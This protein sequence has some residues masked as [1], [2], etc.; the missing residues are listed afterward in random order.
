MVELKI[1]IKAREIVKLT[2][3][4]CNQLPKTEQYVLI[5]QMCR[6][7]ISVASNI[8]EGRE[9]EGHDFKRFLRMAKGSLKELEI[10]MKIA[11]EEYDFSNNYKGANEIYE[12]IDHESKMIFNLLKMQSAERGTRSVDRCRL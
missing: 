11:D 10:Q 5:P 6:A 3:K 4:I 7:A 2:Y 8:A 9:R 1:E 12:L